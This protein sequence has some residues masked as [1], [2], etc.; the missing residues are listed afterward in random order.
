MSLHRID[1]STGFAE[2]LAALGI[3]TGL[4]GAIDIDERVMVETP[5]TLGSVDFW[6]APAEVGAF[7]YFGPGCT[8]ANA[9][10]GRYSSIGP[11]VQVGMTRH[12]ADWLTT[13]PIGYVPDFLNFERHLAGHHPDWTRALPLQEYDL[14]P[15]TRIGNDVWIGSRA[16]IKDGVTIGDG[17]IIG[18]H[19]VVTRDV[20]PYAIVVGSPAQIIRYRFADTLIERLHRLAWWR[21]NLLDMPAL[22]VRDAE[23]CIDELE[24]RIEAGEVGALDTQPIGLVE[25]HRR[26]TEI[27]AFLTQRRA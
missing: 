8:F 3:A 23:G 15:A 24:R 16:F 21:C 7:S 4:H 13:S 5:V 11:G 17:A 10:V 19:S 27:Q 2:H 22:D 14:R 20:P 25:E 1:F 12:P 9:S 18:A 6:Q 26:F